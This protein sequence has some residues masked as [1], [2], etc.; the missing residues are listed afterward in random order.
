MSLSRHFKHYLEKHAIAF[1]PIHHA[2]SASALQ[3]SAFAHV[4]ARQIAKAVVL[5]NRDGTSFVMAV[6]PACSRLHLGWLNTSLQMDLRL[7]EE[8]RLAAIFIDCEL[9]AI[10]PMGTLYRM[11]TIWDE[12][13]KDVGDLYL[14]AGDHETLLRV[15]QQDLPKL[16]PCGV[17]EEISVHQETY[18]EAAQDGMLDTL[19]PI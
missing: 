8:Y 3:S 13:L 1:Q 17:Y 16:N 19:N 10:P 9:G 15:A 11:R 2:H 7:I 14:E 5:E 6:I 18:Y 4:S 12:K